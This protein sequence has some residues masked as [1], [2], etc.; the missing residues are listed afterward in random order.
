MLVGRQLSCLIIREIAVIGISNWENDRKWINW[1]GEHS[2]LTQTHLKNFNWI[3]LRQCRSIQPADELSSEQI[4]QTAIRT[5]IDT[6]ADTNTDTNADK[7]KTNKKPIRMR[8]GMRMRTAADVVNRIHWDPALD[9][10]DFTVVYVDR[11]TGLVAMSLVEFARSR[12]SDS[13]GDVWIPQHRIRRIAYRRYPV[14]DKEDKLD[15]VFGS[16]G[17]QGTIVDY[18]QQVATVVSTT[19]SSSFDR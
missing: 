4:I 18:I 2:N 6:N 7:S 17:Y 3:K 10:S 8:K 9:A 15:Y 13:T 11:F 19:Y 16:T 14:W 5:D 12:C 1:P